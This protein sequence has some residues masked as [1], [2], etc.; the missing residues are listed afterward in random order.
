[1][2]TVDIAILVFVVAFFLVFGLTLSITDWWTSRASHARTNRSTKIAN[3]ES[4]NGEARAGG[5][6]KA[7]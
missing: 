5:T 3:N 4:G 2:T 1:M 6:K 7:A